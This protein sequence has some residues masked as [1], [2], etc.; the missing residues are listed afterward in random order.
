MNTSTNKTNTINNTIQVISFSLEKEEYG[1]NIA[2]VQEINRMVTITHVPRAQKFINLRGQLIPVIDLRLRFG[3]KKTEYTKNTQIVV[4]EIGNKRVG[5]VVDSVAEV[6]RIQE[7]QIE[8]TP[9]IMSEAHSEYI[10]G[11]E[12]LDERLIIILDL[13]KVVPEKEKML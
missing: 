13:E 6:L 1:V 7:N 11:V 4:T 8:E 5:I 9:E 10:N 12:K 2:Q 3:M